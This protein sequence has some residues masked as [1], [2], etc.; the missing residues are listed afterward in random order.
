MAILPPPPHQPPTAWMELRQNC[1]AMALEIEG[2]T[3]HE[4]ALINTARTLEGYVVHGSQELAY[5]YSGFNKVADELVQEL[6]K[7]ASPVATPEQ[8]P[9]NVSALRPKP[10][11][12]KGA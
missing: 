9:E 3:R 7:G 6:A 10:N 8:L 1:L 5:R 11:G 4:L 2:C 12:D